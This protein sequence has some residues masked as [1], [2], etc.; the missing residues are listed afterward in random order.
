[1]LLPLFSALLGLAITLA[2]MGLGMGSIDSLAN[3]QLMHIYGDAV[4]PFLQV[5]TESLESECGSGFTKIYLSS[6]WPLETSTNICTSLSFIQC[7]L[8]R[9]LNIKTTLD[10]YL[11]FA[12]V[13]VTKVALLKPDMICKRC[14]FECGIGKYNTRL[15][16]K[17]WAFRR[18]PYSLDMGCIQPYRTQINTTSIFSLS[19]Q[20]FQ[21]RKEVYTRP[22][23]QRTIGWWIADAQTIAFPTDL[24]YSMY[25]TCIHVVQRSAVLADT[26]IRP[27][28]GTQPVSVRSWE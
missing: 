3:L 26:D 9:C 18:T 8:R 25:T 16:N 10:Q 22:T 14:S 17:V 24:L 12:G 28:V 5:R 19:V 15:R 20:N 2:V 1:M 21:R 6:K 13:S 27:I 4:S 7:C 11:V 23:W